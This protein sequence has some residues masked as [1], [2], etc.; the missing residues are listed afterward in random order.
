[1]MR[2]LL[3]LS[4]LLLTLLPLS[5]AAEERNARLHTQCEQ[6][7]MRACTE[8]GFYLYKEEPYDYEQAYALFS[9][10]CAAQEM[11]ACHNLGSMYYQGEGVSQDLKKAHKLFTLACRHD[12]ADSCHNL[13]FLAINEDQPRQA[14]K[15]WQKACRANKSDSCYNLAHLYT[16]E[17]R[18]DKAQPYYQK[19]CDLGDADGCNRLQTP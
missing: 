4:L 7:N 18:P 10:A 11:T 14:E 19:A 8:L 2:Y 16:Q 1:M 12:D 9:K 3:S 13:G 5:A 15:F 6:G 17:N